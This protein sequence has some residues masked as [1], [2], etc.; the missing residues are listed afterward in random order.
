MPKADFAPRIL[1]LAPPHFL[2]Q[3]I[4][5]VIFCFRRLFQS[6]LMAYLCKLIQVHLF[7]FFAENL[8]AENFRKQNPIHRISELLMAVRKC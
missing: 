5:N 6:L 4:S 2:K 7:R 3:N 1:G 8:G